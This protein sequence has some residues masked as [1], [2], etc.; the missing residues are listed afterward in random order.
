MPPIAVP[1]KMIPLIRPVIPMF[2]SVNASKFGKNDAMEIPNMMVPDDMLIT[3]EENIN[4]TPIPARDPKIPEMRIFS[5]AIFL[6][7]GIDISRP[8]V[9][10][11]QKSDVIIPAVLLPESRISL[12]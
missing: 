8:A 10:D 2:F 12:V 7:N 6:D 4:M 5:G 1:V 3:D 11:P 9:T